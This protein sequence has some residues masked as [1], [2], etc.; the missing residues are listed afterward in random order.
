LYAFIIRESGNNGDIGLARHRDT[1]SLALLPDPGTEHVEDVSCQ[2]VI[3]LAKGIVEALDGEAHPGQ[4]SNRQQI[5]EKGIRLGDPDPRASMERGFQVVFSNGVEITNGRHDVLGASAESVVHVRDNGSH[6]DL[7]IRLHH[8]VIEGDLPIARK[9]PHDHE[10]FGAGIVIHHPVGSGHSLP[11]PR[12]DLLLIH[13]PV[14]PRPYHDA[15]V[16]LWNFLALDHFQQSR[17]QIADRRVTRHVIHDNRHFRSG[18]HKLLQLGR[19][20][21]C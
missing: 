7:Y 21:G 16:P 1:Q 5:V 11:E 13:G 18:L 20:N 8:R 14:S 9:L 15:H 10:V 12:F 19:S 17:E 2:N 3:D 4:P 6:G